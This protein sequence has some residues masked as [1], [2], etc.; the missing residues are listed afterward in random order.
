MLTKSR[1]MFLMIS[2]IASDIFNF[3]QAI[4]ALLQELVNLSSGKI[5]SWRL[6]QNQKWEKRKFGLLFIKNNNQ[7]KIF[8][9]DFEWSPRPVLIFEASLSSLYAVV[10]K[11]V[12]H[13]SLTNLFACLLKT[14]VHIYVKS[15]IIFRLYPSVRAI[16]LCWFELKDFELCFS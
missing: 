8:F 15:W 5:N 2:S 11:M 10:Y 7:K 9:N 16:I 6:Q 14:T 3:L 12:T 13:I 1:S 4:F